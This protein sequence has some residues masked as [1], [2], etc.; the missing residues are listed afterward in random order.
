MTVITLLSG[1]TPILIYQDIINI[2]LAYH[3]C[4]ISVMRETRKQTYGPILTTLETFLFHK[5]R[6]G[7]WGGVLPYTSL[8]LDVERYNDNMLI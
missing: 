1:Q 2:Y 8:N 6:Y 3:G 4:Q 7:Y 5:N